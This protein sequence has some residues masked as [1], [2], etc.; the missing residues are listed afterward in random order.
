MSNVIIIP[1]YNHISVIEP[2]LSALERF[3]LPVIMI[4]DG[5]DTKSTIFMQ[6]LRESYHYLTL[7]EHE[8]NQGKGAAI[9]T[10]LK[11]ADKMG[12]SHALQIDADGQHDLTDIDKMLAESA[13]YPNALI[14]GQPIYDESVP[15]HRYYLRYLTHVWVWIETLSFD[16]KDSMCGFRVYPLLSSTKLINEVNLGTRMDFDIEILVRLYWR[17]IEMRFLPTAVDYPEGGISH[18]RAWQDN[19]LISW[20]HTRLFF[21]ML[22]RSP[23]LLANKLLGKK[24]TAKHIN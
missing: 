18:F 10:G 20:L 3:S 1:N 24:I 13:A 5:S 8:T 11:L 23:Y 16:I 12:F 2:L 19:V 6:R 7:V 9:Q 14:S 22:L 4:N 21:G 17:N 15:K